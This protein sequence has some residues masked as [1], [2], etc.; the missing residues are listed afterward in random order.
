MMGSRTN[1]MIIDDSY[2]NRMLL[3]AVLEELDMHIIEVHSGMK[4]LKLLTETIPDIILLDMCM[5]LMNGLDFLKELQS[6]RK[7][8]PVIVISVLDDQAY[9]KL[10]YQHGAYD[11]LIKPL[12]IDKLLSAIARHTEYEISIH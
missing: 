2:T 12:D 1:I 3:K 10:A 6:I 7:N 4:A 9:M 8:I 11:Y 5:P